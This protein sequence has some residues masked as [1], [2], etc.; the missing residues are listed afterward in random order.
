MNWTTD[1]IPDQAGRLAL[2]TGANSG[3]SYN[4]A[5]G[6]AFGTTMA[7]SGDLLYVGVREGILN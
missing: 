4:G 3:F 2:I 5:A 6:A 7:S 1:S